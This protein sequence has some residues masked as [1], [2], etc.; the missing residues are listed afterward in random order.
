M[1]AWLELA[2]SVGGDTFDYSLGRDVLHLSITDAMGHGVA[3]VLI[4]T[5]CVGSLRNTRRPGA[6]LLEQAAAANAALSEYAPRVADDVYATGVVEAL[7]YTVSLIE[8]Q[9]GWGAFKSFRDS[10]DFFGAENQFASNLRP[11]L[12]GGDPGGGICRRRLKLPSRRFSTRSSC[13]CRRR[14]HSKPGWSSS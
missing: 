12:G 9:G 8:A 3:S 10:W 4:A 7:E 5:L 13:S 14:L 2:A 1:S 11:G 6:S